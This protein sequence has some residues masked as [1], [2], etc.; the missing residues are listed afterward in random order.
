MERGDNQAA[1]L[2]HY[3][4]QMH[5]L[6]LFYP[7]QQDAPFLIAFTGAIANGRKKYRAETANLTSHLEYRQHD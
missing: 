7:P 4:N 5:F 3:R 2:L 6:L 1:W